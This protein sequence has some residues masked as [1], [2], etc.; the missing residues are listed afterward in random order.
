MAVQ[1]KNCECPQLIFQWR[2]APKLIAS[3]ERNGCVLYMGFIET[4]LELHGCC[5]FPLI[6]VGFE[7]AF[8]FNELSV[9]FRAFSFKNL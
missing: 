4:N 7:P 1:G 2:C 6:S 9:I 5:M 8:E 3:E